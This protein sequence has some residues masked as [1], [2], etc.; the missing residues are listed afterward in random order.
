M[1]S[2]F[3]R[4]RRK[5]PM[6]D[7]SEFY[8]KL[9]RD[10]KGY[11]QVVLNNKKYL[12]HRLF[13]EAF[14]PNPEGK[15]QVDI[16]EVEVWRDISVAPG[17]M[18]SSFGRVR[19]KKPRSD[20]REFFPKISVQKSN[21]YY[22]V[23]LNRKSYRLHRLLAEAFIPNPENK[24]C[25]DHIDRDPL[26]NCLSNLRWATHTENQWN[27]GKQRNNTSGYT[28]VSFHK[29]TGKWQTYIKIDG[30][31][32]YLGLYETPEE[33]SKAYKTAARELH[34]EFYRET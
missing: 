9:V 26:N 2:S 13:A 21:G 5:K 22:C 27:R 29:A 10:S 3:G 17:Y 23:K 16:T 1:I 31:N 33:A 15:P 25:V 8:P 32:E 7:G 12:L 19:R 24:P 18:I 20:G 34:G 11:I 4:V 30:K 14:I 6:M 28:G